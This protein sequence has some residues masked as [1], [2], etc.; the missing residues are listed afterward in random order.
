MG[1]HSKKFTRKRIS[2]WANF[3]SRE[4]FKNVYNTQTA[5]PNPIDRERVMEVITLTARMVG[6]KLRKRNEAD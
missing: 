4:F 1:K 3:E 5:F 6:F 2:L